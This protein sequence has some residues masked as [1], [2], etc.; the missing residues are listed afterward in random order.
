M[1]FDL[2]HGNFLLELLDLIKTP[3]EIFFEVAFNVVSHHLHAV[4]DVVVLA[5]I[6]LILDKGCL[7][8]VVVL[9]VLSISWTLTFSEWPIE[10]RL[11][12][13]QLRGTRE[14]CGRNVLRVFFSRSGLACL[15]CL[16][17][18]LLTTL[19][20]CL[21][22]ICAAGLLLIAGLGMPLFLDDARVPPCPRQELTLV[23]EVADSKM[24][25]LRMGL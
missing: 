13:K 15:R 19:A 1:I 9:A 6:E 14:C 18:V 12:S 23:N 7:L 24:T 4:V 22:A 16:I 11:E 21:L 20:L 5:C 3:N 17:I 2:L 25:G 10:L 8:L